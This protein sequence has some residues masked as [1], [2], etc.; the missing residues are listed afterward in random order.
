MSTDGRVAPGFTVYPAI[1]LRA[2]RCVRLRQGD[3][4]RQ[5]VFSADPEEVARAFVAEGALALH[6]VDLDGA[7]SGRPAQLPLVARVVRAAG[8]PVQLGGGLRSA[9]DV[10]A[11]L[12]AGVW[13]VVLGTR[14]L[15][16]VFFAGL[17]RRFG[18]ERVIAGLDVRGDRVAIEGWRGEADLGLREAATRLRALGA[19]EAVC[20]QVRRDG[21][22]SGPDLDAVDVVRATGLRVVASG[23][24]AG[25]EDVR[26][27][28][29]LASGGVAGVVVGRALYTGALRLRD[30]LDAAC[31][32][33]G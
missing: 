5:E 33:A 26:A 14:A 10:E 20:T 21:M 9:E 29:A 22:L 32:G 28:A 11:A 8:V 4:E 12:A 27:L 25:A 16:P 7:F 24:V 23:G 15:D 31:R 30:A 18:P 19:E 6:V 13:R 1:D 3:P 2:G 17:L